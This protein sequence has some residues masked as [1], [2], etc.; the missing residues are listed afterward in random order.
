MLED[1]YDPMPFG[2]VWKEDYSSDIDFELLNEEL[3]WEDAENG[4]D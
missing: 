3:D 2:N 4:Q 1:G